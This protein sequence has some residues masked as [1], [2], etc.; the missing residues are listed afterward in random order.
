MIKSI[1]RYWPGGRAA[2]WVGLLV[3][4]GL[5]LTLSAAPVPLAEVA[6]NRG[7]GRGSDL[8]VM[9][10]L[11]SGREVPFL[12]DAG[13]PVTL[14]D[15]S[16]EP[17]LGPYQGTELVRFVWTG[18]ARFRAFRAPKLYLGKLGLQTEPH[19]FTYD[20]QRQYPVAPVAG[21]L[22]MD[23][24]QHYCVQLDF[25][26]NR[27]R[28]LD[29][30]QP[31]DPAWGRPWPLIEHDDFKWVGLR[32]AFAGEPA[33]ELRIDTSGN[34]DGVLQAKTFEALR[35]AEGVPE[36]NSLLIRSASGQFGGE[37]YTNL[38]W[39]KRLD[40]E[41]FGKTHVGLRFWARHLV[42][43]NFPHQM[44]YLRRTS[45][46]P[47][48]EE[49]LAQDYFSQGAKKYLDDLAFNGELPGCPAADS[50]LL[51]DH[52]EIQLEVDEM[53]PVPAE[54]RPYAPA[55]RSFSILNKADKAVYFYTVVQAHVSTGWK[56]QRIWQLK[57][58]AERLVPKELPVP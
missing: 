21:I 17:E 29:P 2:A 12:V 53:N 32:E 10:R 7:A 1:V 24:L 36:T 30:D 19:I 51:L 49:S 26:A 20:M 47:L 4:C 13:Y 43:L 48:P 39:V 40:K 58:G 57:V 50:Y 41:Y 3:A 27:L 54:E 23:V 33:R 44:M 46:G 45:V 35:R 37:T 22:G 6:F 25:T 15:R 52:N 42:T 18:Q 16:L 28:L 8:F 55:V 9:V 14:L 11:P 38:M 5:S 56:L 34:V 31:V